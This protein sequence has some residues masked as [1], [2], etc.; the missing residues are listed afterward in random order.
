MLLSLAVLVT[1]FGAVAPVTPK[2]ASGVAYIGKGYNIIDGNPDGVK[3]GGKR[4]SK[5][6]SEKASSSG[7]LW[8]GYAGAGTRCSGVCPHRMYEE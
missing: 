3:L 7:Q 5:R 8:G 1:V 6:S 2:R 4:F